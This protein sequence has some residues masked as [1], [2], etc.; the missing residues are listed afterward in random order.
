MAVVIVVRIPNEG[1]VNGQ[2]NGCHRN[3]NHIG[4]H[5]ENAN[6]LGVFRRNRIDSNGILEAGILVLRLDVACGLVFEVFGLD[7]VGVVVD[8][9]AVVAATAPRIRR[10]WT[11]C[12]GQVAGGGHH[13]G[14]CLDAHTQA[15]VL[16]V[17]AFQTIGQG[18]DD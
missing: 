17:H 16:A 13:G 4:E 11:C 8:A 9:G 7:A 1:V 12:G 14:R 5:S 2:E 18:H 10:R 3:G 15:L 6:N